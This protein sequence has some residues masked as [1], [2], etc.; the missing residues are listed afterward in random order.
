M[1][2]LEGAKAVLKKRFPEIVK[3]Y[4]EDATGY[5]K[6]VEQGLAGG[7]ISQVVKNAHPLKSSSAGLGLAGVSGIARAMEEA[8][9]NGGTVETIRPMVGPLKEALEFAAPK[10]R[11]LLDE[12]V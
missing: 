8:A 6:G 10:L 12:A 2:D 9:R 7:D 11:A 4:L 1:S 5:L 3:C